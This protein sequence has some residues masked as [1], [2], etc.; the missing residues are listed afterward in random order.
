MASLSIAD[1]V[2][3]V[4]HSGEQL[5]RRGDTVHKV[6]ALQD[7]ERGRRLEVEEILGYT[8]RKGEELSLPL[9]T[10]ATCYRLLAGIARSLQRP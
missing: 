2:A 4:R 3:R 6:S 9:P 1:A 10:V 8:V 7:L 5:E